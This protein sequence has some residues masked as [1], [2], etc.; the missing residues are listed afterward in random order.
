MLKYNIF[1]TEVSYYD[2]MIVNLKSLMYARRMKAI[3]SAFYHYRYNEQ[4]VLHSEVG[5]G[6]RTLFD[7]TINASV[8]LLKFS[9][10]IESVDVYFSRQFVENVPYRANSF[11]KSLLRIS[12]KQQKKFYEQ[13]DEHQDVVELAK[14]YLNKLNKLL[15]TNRWIAFFLHPIDILYRK[16]R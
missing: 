11:T 9:K 8:V 12:Y 7:A 5:V 13:V 1:F 15:V 6:G 4:S 2:D 10:E 16:L 14:P 3:P